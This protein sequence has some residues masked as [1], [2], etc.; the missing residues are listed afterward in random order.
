MPH[1]VPDVEDSHERLQQAVAAQL[2]QPDAA[3]A[4]YF[5]RS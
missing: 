1:F 3:L 4:R 2:A 5:Y